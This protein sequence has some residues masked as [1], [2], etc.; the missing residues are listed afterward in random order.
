VEGAEAGVLDG[1]AHGLS[2]GRVR[3]VYVEVHGMATKTAVRDRLAA[4][5]YRVTDEYSV[6]PD[7]TMLRAE[8]SNHDDE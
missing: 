3:V 4:A 2:R 7:E 6:G 1:F 5:G 8:V